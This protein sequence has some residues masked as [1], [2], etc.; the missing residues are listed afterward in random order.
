MVATTFAADTPLA[1]TRLVATRL[2]S[3]ELVL[4][5]ECKPRQH[6]YGSLILETLASSWNPERQV[7]FTELRYTDRSVALL[8]RF[9]AIYLGLPINCQWLSYV[10]P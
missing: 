2:H 7:E 10:P 3:C 5:M 1:V 4:L 9:R 8:R 6:A